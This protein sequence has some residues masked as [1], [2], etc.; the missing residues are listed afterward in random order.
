MKI[1]DLGEICHIMKMKSI[2]L[3]RESEMAVEEKV[4]MYLNTCDHNEKIKTS[5]LIM[6]LMER[7]NNVLLHSVMA[8]YDHLVNILGS[9]RTYESFIIEYKYG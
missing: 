5:I 2:F 6:M 7:V 1:D 4:S 3:K 8:T 9:R